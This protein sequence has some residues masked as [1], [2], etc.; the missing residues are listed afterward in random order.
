LYGFYTGSRTKPLL[1]SAGQQACREEKILIRSK[2]A[3]RQWEIYKNADGRYMAPEGEKDDCVMADLLAIWAHFTH[4]APLVRKFTDE[5]KR[6]IDGATRELSQEETIF[7]ANMKK[8]KKQQ[9][10]LQKR[11]RVVRADAIL[12]RYF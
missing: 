12:G 6:K 9:A 4:V 1:V 7:W 8:M 3:L 10:D 11:R 5:E 2:T